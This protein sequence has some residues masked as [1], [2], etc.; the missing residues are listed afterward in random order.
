MNKSCATIGFDDGG[1]VDVLAALDEDHR[2][3]Q[4]DESFLVFIVQLRIRSNAGEL[5]HGVDILDGI[6]LIIRSPS[7]NDIWNRPKMITTDIASQEDEASPQAIEHRHELLKF[8]VGGV[9]N[10][11]QPYVADANVQRVAVADAAGYR[12]LIHESAASIVVLRIHDK[13]WCQRGRVVPI[14]NH[15]ANTCATWR[16]V[17]TS[18]YCQGATCGKRRKHCSGH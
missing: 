15:P 14:R 9:G 3:N 11:A 2:V 1:A 17:A 10:F 6:V 18:S 8:V 4:V 5:T 16:T 7:G 12:F 13:G